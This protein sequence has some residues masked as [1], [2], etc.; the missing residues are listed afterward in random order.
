MVVMNWIIIASD[1]Y[2]QEAKKLEMFFTE[3]EYT[4]SV[5]FVSDTTI[6]SVEQFYIDLHKA[7]H[8]V[9]IS[10]G[11]VPMNPH[12]FYIVVKR[13]KNFSQLTFSLKIW[14]IYFQILKSIFQNI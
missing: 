1:K 14:K 10:D 2:K 8:C 9:F 7:T 13:K 5:Y 6:E 11:T 4:P 12:L 3:R